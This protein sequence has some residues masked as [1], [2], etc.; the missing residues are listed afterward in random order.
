MKTTLG[1]LIINNALP[2][3]LRDH[4]R[5]LDKKG[6]GDLLQLVAE[7]HPDKYRQIAK[8]LSDVGRQAAFTTGGHSFGLQSL[9]QTLAG[10]RMRHD[11]GGRLQKLYQAKMTDEDRDRQVLS[12]ASEYQRKLADEVLEEAVS[13]DNPLARQL[14]GAGRGNKYQLNSLLGG[15]ILY[16]D[17]RGDVVPVPVLRTYAMGLRPH[18]YFAGAFGAR[19]GTMDTK[20]ATQDAGFF[21]KQLTQAA[22][23]LRVTSLDDDDTPYDESSPRG[24]ISDTSDQDNVGALLSH[25]IGGYPRNSEITPRML[26]DL[27]SQGIDRILTRS[28]MVGGPD[29]GGVYGRD[30]G[31]REKG[32]VAPNGDFVGIAA[33]QAIAE[34]VS[35]AQLSS[36]HSGG[37]AGA[38]TAGAVSGFKYINQLVQVPKR[39]KG[40]AAHSQF[41][42]RVT[43]VDKA[44]QG[45]H[46]VHIAGEPHYVGGD[47]SVT[48]QPGDDVEAGDTIS[49]GIPN[50]SEIV[51][52]K[53][54]GEGRAYF[55]R[56]FHKALKDSNTSANRRNLELLSRG[57]INHVRLDDEIG[58]WNPDDVV[59]YQLLE[60][61]WQPRPGYVTSAPKAAVG[62]YLERPVLHHTIGT[63]IRPS[64]LADMDHFGVK[65]LTVHRD[66]PP[67]QT[68]MVRG[69]ANVAHDPD[70]QTRLL[71]SY[72]SKSLLEGARRGA[73]SDA[74][75]SS[76]VPALASGQ[77]L[78]Q[79]AALEL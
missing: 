24:F 19:K 52:H 73:V 68:E 12:A 71:G 26:K 60:R 16:T 44:P 27:K 28:P 17:H 62:Q 45:G 6:V 65:E 36:K 48:V 39:F 21:A 13:M 31:R 49:E 4:N 72:Q 40:G 50:P 51:K 42:G 56:A 76:Y 1:Q 7:K 46:Y 55:V 38:A 15:D 18:E 53:G 20:T 3:D 47:Y 70:W 23:R 59:P 33:A 41:D 54:I 74:A 22:H 35:Q 78:K 63:K 57:L 61:G 43:R 2:E 77:M 32:D 66:P 58:D 9:R 8:D 64:M 67:F 37:V 34:P 10:R 14:K 30:V 29:D 75:G 5:V 11:L 25:P 69:M 79:Q